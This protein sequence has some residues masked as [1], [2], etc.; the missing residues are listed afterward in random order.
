MQGA[1]GE[2]N[3][4]IRYAIMALVLSIVLVIRFRRMNQVRPLKVERL[5]IVPALYLVITV[6]A[7]AAT[8][9]DAAG[10]ALSVIAFAAG[11]ALGWQ[12]GRLMKIDVDRETKAVTTVQSPMAFLFIVVLIAIR[13]GMRS[14]AQ[15]GAGGLFHMSAASLTDIL[16]AFALGLLSVQR[17]EMFLRARRLVEEARR[18]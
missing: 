11:A 2:P 3:P 10:W 7:F 6:V 15:G 1:A 9:P 12:R 16:V 5:W 14:M 17:V 4:L 8:P 18:L 13:S